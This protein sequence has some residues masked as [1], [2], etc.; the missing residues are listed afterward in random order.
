MPWFSLGSYCSS[1]G[2]LQECEIQIGLGLFQSLKASNLVVPEFIGFN[3]HADAEQAVSRGYFAHEYS[4][5]VQATQVA[6]QIQPI[7]GS[8]V[9]TQVRLSSETILKLQLSPILSCFRVPARV[10]L[11]ID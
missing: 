6:K 1:C 7:S 2:Y 4:S 5:I 8:C 10:L 11:L 9:S 3:T